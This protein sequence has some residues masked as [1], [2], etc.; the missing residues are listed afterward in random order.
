MENGEKSQRR[1]R[2]FG[3]A[4]MPH[5]SSMGRSSPQNLSATGLRFLIETPRLEIL[6]T[7]TKQKPLAIP[8]R[9]K[10]ARLH[11]IGDRQFSNRECAIRIRDKFPKISSIQISNRER[12][13]FF[14]HANRSARFFVHWP[15]LTRHSPAP[16]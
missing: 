11:E 8:N 3:F 9:D 13:A 16:F 2:Q 14:H 4:S 7:S 6:T 12:I 10:N 15:V 5:L 1:K